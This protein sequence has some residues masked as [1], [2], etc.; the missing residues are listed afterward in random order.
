[1]EKLL[2]VCLMFVLAA[3]SYSSP[4]IFKVTKEAKR[5]QSAKPELDAESKKINL[6]ALMM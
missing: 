3:N 5:E 4:L 2:G 6:F 1:M